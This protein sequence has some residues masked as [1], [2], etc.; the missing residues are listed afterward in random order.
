M[1]R[2]KDWTDIMRVLLEATGAFPT[3][4]VRVPVTG[5][6]NLGGFGGAALGGGPYAGEEY[7]PAPPPQAGYGAAAL[8]AG[9]NYGYPP[10][11]QR[12]F[13]PH[14]PTGG[15]VS[16]SPPA[17]PPPAGAS[18]PPAADPLGNLIAQALT[19]MNKPEDPWSRLNRIGVA[20]LDAT[21][22]P[23]APTVSQNLAAGDA[24]NMKQRMAKLQTAA[25]LSG[26]QNA[27]KQTLMQE[28]A[29]KS[30]EK[31]RGTQTKLAYLKMA[32]EAA[33]KAA[34]RK[35][36]FAEYHRK[37]LKDNR[38]YLISLKKLALMEADAGAKRLKS[39]IT[40]IA[41]L[42]KEWYR[43]KTTQAFQG[44]IRN[45]FAT[46]M[47]QKNTRLG[48]AALVQS[49]ARMMDPDSVVH[50]EEIRNWTKNASASLISVLQDA[51]KK[52]A[53][54]KVTQDTFDN[55]RLLAKQVYVQ[56]ARIYNEARSR[57]VKIGQRYKKEG[58]NPSIDLGPAYNLSTEINQSRASDVRSTG[59]S[60]GGVTVT[61]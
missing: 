6:Y 37:V 9:T 25:T 11:A 4:G 23:G 45:F 47:T 61:P 3:R 50:G 28:R 20:M 58:F 15:G 41:D 19:G 42:R 12:G 39:G 46:A 59:I 26:M 16:T 22:R 10:V 54:G 35:M 8:G 29:Q 33:T 14:T 34:D 36:K 55:L 1:T 48:V 31:W 57:Y 7:P 51:L 43:L 60:G 52:A 5:N 13:T 18:A 56:R 21:G 17:T 38:D 44:D 2:R 30:L 24:L 49:I 53:E 27:R 32:A 40:G